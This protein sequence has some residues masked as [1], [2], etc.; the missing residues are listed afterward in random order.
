QVGPHEPAPACS[1]NQPPITE[2]SHFPGWKW[3]ARQRFPR[4]AVGMAD[5]H[6]SPPGAAAKIGPASH[7]AEHCSHPAARRG[8]APAPAP[9]PLE[10]TS[11]AARTN[12]PSAPP[13][14]PAPK[15]P[16]ESKAGPC[17]TRGSECVVQSSDGLV[18]VTAA[19]P[20]ITPTTNRTREAADL[21]ST[22]TRFHVYPPERAARRGANS[23][24]R[25]D[26]GG[27]R[28]VPSTKKD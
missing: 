12:R 26:Y 15:L 3:P 4:P 8:G 2:A 14:L 5:P 6:G 11:R 28:A 13:G 19:L 25:H 22:R 9:V 24:G 20:V 18:L 27:Q 7:G 17:V 16:T 21:A 1:G 23:L 10:A